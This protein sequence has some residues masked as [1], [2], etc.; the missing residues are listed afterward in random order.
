MTE[1]EKSL[2]TWE[3]VIVD[4]FENKISGT[5]LFK[6]REYINKKQKEI[7][8]EKNHDKKDK[9][10]KAKKIKNNQLIQLR[11]KA[12]ST[13]IREWIIKTSKKSL[14]EGKRI[15]KASHVLKFSHS[16]SEPE[17]LKVQKRC[18][19][20]FL[21]TNSFKRELI[22]DLAHSNGNLISISRFLALKLKKNQIIDLIL[23]D[24]FP[25]L[26]PFSKD[27]KQLSEWRKGFALLVEEREIKTG[28]KTK[29]VYFPNKKNPVLVKDYDLIIPL[30]S[31]SLSQEIYSWVTDIKYGEEQKQIKEF[32]KPTGKK[33]KASKYHPG[34][35][36]NLPD[37]GVLKFGG[38]QPQNVS[39][40]NKDRGGQCFLFSTQPPTWQSQLK[41]PAT[42]QSLFR[43]L[44]NATIKTEI[45]YLRD[46]LMRFAELDL[47]IKDPKRK[48][49]LERWVNNIIDEFLF[50]VATIQSLS[51]GWSDM[52]DIKLKKE[53]QHLLD[54]YRKDESFQL[55]RHNTDW[56]AVIR[57]DFAQWLNHQL[58]GRDKKFTPRQAHTRLWKKLL[59][60]PLREYVEI[61]EQEIKQKVREIV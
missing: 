4:F 44:Y 48:R 3:D 54:P 51:P 46:F 12:P 57:A 36:V 21:S 34:I 11:R 55:A 41:P 7:E 32:K 10:I 1:A 52:E 9:L 60:Q 6:A 38:A 13:E 16:S 47:S 5:N 27:S 53:H 49:H 33:V 30:F 18:E 61:I 26:D 22:Y 50:Y 45:D 40:L 58:R 59:E 39:M 28:E 19:K 29:Q 8:S 24:K 14:G 17:G 23:N 2:E 25:F 31:S 56:Q 42:R 35:A 43:G 15:I 20:E 37:L